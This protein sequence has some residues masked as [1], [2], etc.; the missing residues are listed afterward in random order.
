MKKYTITILFTLLFLT[1]FAQNN[2]IIFQDDFNRNDIG[3]DWDVRFGNWSIVDNTLKHTGDGSFN[4]NFIVLNEG[5]TQDNYII[6]C[7]I[8][9][10]SGGFFEDGIAIGYKIFTTHLPGGRY[11]DDYCLNTMS[12]WSQDRVVTARCDRLENSYNWTSTQN[13]NLNFNIQN[14]VWYHFKIRVAKNTDETTNVYFYIDDVLYL[15]N[16]FML[17]GNKIGLGCWK[18]QYGQIFYFDDFL[19]IEYDP[20]TE[21]L[22]AYYPFNANANDETGNGN[23]GIV[24]GATLTYDRF[25]NPNSAYYFDGSNDEILIDVTPDLEN[26]SAGNHSYSLWLTIES[27]TSVP[28]FV[29]DASATGAGGNQRGLRFWSNNQPVFKWVTNQSSYNAPASENISS[30]GDWY[31]IVGV[32]N[33]GSGKI[34]INGVEKGSATSSGTL[35]PIELMKVG[36]ISGGGTGDG[37]FHGK[38]DDIRIYKRSLTSNEIQNLYDPELTTVRIL[39]IISDEFLGNPIENAVVSVTGDYTATYPTNSNGEY[40]IN[41]LPF[42]TGYHLFV[43]AE[44]YQSEEITNINLTS[45]N[46]ILTVDVSLT[47]SNITPVLLEMNP[48]PNPAISKIGQGGT[49]HRYYFVKDQ[50][51][52]EPAP[53]VQVIVEDENSMQYTFQSNSKGI[54]DIGIFADNIDGGDVGSTY[55]YS[56]VE[57]N[58]EPL[59]PTIDFICEFVDRIYSKYWDS[60]EFGK[61]GVSFLSIEAN[62]GSSIVLTESDANLSGAETLYVTRQA[63]AGVGVDFSVG[64]SAGVSCGPITAGAGATAG[65]GGSISGITEDYYQFPHQNYTKNQA[66]VQYLLFADGNYKALDNTLIRLLSK[67]EEI[68]GQ[69]STL[70]TA[71]LGDKKGLDV[72]LET[73]ASANVGIGVGD[74]IG[75]G[76]DANIGAEGHVMFN[77]IHHDQLSENE[78]SFAVSGRFQAAASA[79]AGLTF[80]LPKEDDNWGNEFQSRLNI[81]DVDGTRGFEF[82]IFKDVTT[83]IFT[84]YRIKFLHRNDATGWEEVMTYEIAGS[85]VYGATQTL[86]EQF[87]Q[88]GTLNNPSSDGNIQVSNDLF[89]QLTFALFN[90]LYDLQT[91]EQGDA[92]ITYQKDIKEMT[93]ISG[94]EIN[95]KGKL[96]VSLLQ[97]EVGGGTSFEEGKMM[98]SEK[99]KW[100]WGHH[101]A[102]ENY[103]NNI[104]EINMEYQQVIQDIVDE[105][106]LWIRIGLGIMNK[107]SWFLKDSETTFYIMDSLGV[108]TAAYIDFPSSSLPTTIDSI[109]CVS[110]GWYGS[111]TRQKLSDLSPHLKKVYQTNRQ[112]AEESFGMKY[113]I[114]GM[115]QLEPLD[116]LLVDTAYMTIIYTDS[117]VVDIDETRLGM[118]KEDKGNHS[119]IHIGGIVDTLN[120][121]VTAPITDLSLYTLAPTMPIGTFSLSPSND[122][123]YADS[124][125]T[126]TITSGIIYYNNSDTVDNGELFTINT[127]SGTIIT[128]DVNTEIEGI[129]VEAF[130]GEISFTIKSSYI[131]GVPKLSVFSV[132]GSAKADTSIVF[133]DTIPPI[134]PIGFTVTAKNEKVTLTWR[135]NLEKDISGYIIYFDTDTDSPPYE[136]LATVYGFPSP[137]IIGKDTS[138]TVTGLTNDTTYYFTVTAYDISG[139]ESDYSIPISKVPNAMSSTVT[140][141]N[142]TITDGN[143]EC[144]NATSII[145]VA[146]SGTTVDIQ[147]GGEATFIAGETIYLMPGFHSHSGSTTH[148]YITTTGDYCSSQQSMV[149]NPDIVYDL[150]EIIADEEARVNIYP[151]PTT[152]NF[153]I[154]FKGVETTADILLLNFQG[155]RL[156]EKRCKEQLKIELNITHLPPGMYIVVI[157]AKTELITKKIIKNY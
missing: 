126:A 71:Y 58:G 5:I 98:L 61:L 127:E 118:Y 88:I 153:T 100:V 54:L 25:G 143:Q 113:G 145:T 151:N 57:L 63:R 122:S 13:T 120:N 147:S 133:Y 11:V 40:T 15:Q 4:S 80:D 75:L 53:L 117:M 79:Q 43:S 31:H 87:Q 115:F 12:T 99:G 72:M 139:N 78:F 94:F 64:A 19:V 6:T 24:Y 21:D 73:Y 121:T 68:F 74:N 20:V 14:N 116:T 149:A 92:T 129:Q 70:E 150:P 85:E 86:R 60:N 77:A 84:R 128:T 108:D 104:P 2:N 23:N 49:V 157:K 83:G 106:P 154:D 132:F 34:Y 33:N 119:W 110:W 48:N 50:T 28:K 91:N 96:G 125:S 124:I 52:G 69:Q 59:E 123:I 10:Q 9:W 8:K 51:T 111:S 144:Y 16:T 109:Y 141:Q 101:L 45:A 107:F 44:G 131:A 103:G 134:P 67:I 140:I 89:S 155:N 55:S 56:I 97:V 36:N 93:D 46:S 82:S 1:H 32:Y 136:G 76:A 62:R 7:K 152:G 30:N 137:I 105:I 22:A 114:G 112:R 148:A 138:F 38:I 65:V 41:N 142:E 37:Y 81:L 47:I 135:R 17:E 18:G 29:I 66:L 39:G 26:Y 35:T 3:N 27:N 42:G 102:L 90:T 130:N 156:I 146:G 95:I